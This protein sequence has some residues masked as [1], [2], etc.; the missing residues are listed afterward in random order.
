VSGFLE[1]ETLAFMASVVLFCTVSTPQRSDRNVPVYA[2]RLGRCEM[3]SFKEV[4]V[5]KARRGG[6]RKRKNK[7]AS[8]TRKVR[9]RRK[10]TERGCA[11]QFLRYRLGKI[12]VCAGKLDGCFGRRIIGKVVV[13]LVEVDGSHIVV[14]I[15][16]YIP[17]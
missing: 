14:R 4:C 11:L 2:R 17:C 13:V 15:G 16:I 10:S 5:S 8:N 1:S 3:R 9:L 12:A 6:G 7:N